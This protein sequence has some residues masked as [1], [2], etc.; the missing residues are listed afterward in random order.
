MP[1]H[2][3]PKV[4]YLDSLSPPTR[5]ELL[6]L[7]LVK[8][9]QPKDILVRQ[10]EPGGI[11]FLLLTG[12]VNVVANVENGAETL[13][14]IRHP[15]DVLGEMAV[16]GG[17]PRTATVTAR[18][19]STALVVS[20]E[21]FKRFVASHPDAAMALTAVSANRLRQANVY[22]ADAAGYEVE[23]RIARTLLY[24]AQRLATK[25]DGFW[26]V[27]LMQGELAMLIGAKEGTVQK[28]LRTMK[29]IVSSRR[30]RILIHD[31]AK[32]A[33]LAEIEPP[34]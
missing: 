24:Q 2:L 28:A 22:R 4:S 19:H 26:V 11:L 20:G 9:Y 27:D 13:L 1:P 14:A 25:V 15:G 10:G 30:G 32:L 16:F 21:E 5:D 3:W 7:G 18:V 31:V 33:Q 29:D 34:I 6:R 8:A 12:R 17:M 23:Q